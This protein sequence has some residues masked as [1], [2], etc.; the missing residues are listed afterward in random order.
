MNGQ[1][2]QKKRQKIVSNF[3]SGE[4]VI[5]FTTDVLARGLDFDDVPLVI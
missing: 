2:V 5:L 3:K 1:M 4:K